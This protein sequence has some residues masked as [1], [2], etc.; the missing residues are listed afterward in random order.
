[1]TK[2]KHVKYLEEFSEKIDY[3]NLRPGDIVGDLGE[4]NKSILLY[5]VECANSVPDSLKYNDHHVE[6][7]LGYGKLPWVESAFLIG[8]RDISGPNDDIHLINEG[9][10][11]HNYGSLM[12]S[13]ILP[14]ESVIPLTKSRTLGNI[15]RKL[16]NYGLNDC[17]K[18]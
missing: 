18:N 3:L 9:C 2:P 7:S 6:L 17:K 12:A 8:K 16:E 5:F 13:I 1:M 4:D 11:L 14:T 10:D 15:V